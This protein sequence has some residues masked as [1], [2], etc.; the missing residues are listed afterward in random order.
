[1]KIERY[2]KSKQTLPVDQK[3][4]VVKIFDGFSIYLSNYFDH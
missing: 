3:M 4:A 1:M 2:K